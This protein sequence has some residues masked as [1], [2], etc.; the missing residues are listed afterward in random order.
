MSTSIH[1][2]IYICS[3]RDLDSQSG[4]CLFTSAQDVKDVV[5]VRRQVAFALVSLE[6]LIPNN[7]EVALKLQIVG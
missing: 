7:T 6:L 1:M 5:A 2:C 4:L 3:L